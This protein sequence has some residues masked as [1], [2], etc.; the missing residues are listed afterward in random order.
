MFNIS[1]DQAQEFALWSFWMNL[2][3]ALF[4]FTILGIIYLRK[5]A[6]KKVELEEVKSKRTIVKLA[7]K[8]LQ[9]T[10]GMLYI[11]EL[12]ES[13]KKQAEENGVE[14]PNDKL[15]GIL[16]EDPLPKQAEEKS[17]IDYQSLPIKE[18]HKLA[19]ARGIKGA[20]RMKKDKLINLL[21]KGDEASSNSA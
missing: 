10:N 12:Y 9:F 14:I 18:L 7:E 19:L 3:I 16:S 5:W 1:T 20:T 6:K 8:Q 4:F 11:Q 2:G 13:K 15:D 21:V 17:K